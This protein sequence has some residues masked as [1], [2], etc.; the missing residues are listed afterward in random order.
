MNCWTRLFAIMRKELR[1]LRRDRLTFAM[2]AGMPLMQLMLFGYAINTDVREL[3][4]ALADQSRSEL[5]RTLVANIQASQVLRVVTEVADAEALEILIQRGEVAAGIFIPADFTRRLQSQDRPAAQLLVDGSDP[6]LLGAVRQLTGMKLSWRV[7]EPSRPQPPLF[8]VRNHF[9]P[10][11]RSAVQIVPGLIGVILS[12]T[13]VLFTAV[14]IVRERERGNLEMLITTPV[15]TIE[16]MV[17][18]LIPYVM[19]GLIQVTLIMAL[20]TLFFEVPIRGS[21]SHIYLASLAFIIANLG[22]GLFISTAAQNQFQAMQMT[23]F[24]FLPSILLSGF[25]FPFDGMPPPAQWLAEILPLTHFVR[26]IRGLMLRGADLAELIPDL[27]ALGIFFA[28]TLI[29][30]L[31]RFRKRLD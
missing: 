1:Q 19:I 14:S 3:R 21:F 26:L 2:I 10:E 15:K 23:F 30:A 24:F 20:G 4:A 31:R 5:S 6:I 7:R 22:I 25:M 18:K 29:L 27:Q 11:R 28:V 8:E 12:M 17:G 9:N 16:L 13:M